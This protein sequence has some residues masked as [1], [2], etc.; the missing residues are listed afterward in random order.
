MLL[1]GEHVLVHAAAF[2]VRD[3][4]VGVGAVGLRHGAALVRQVGCGAQARIQVELR[5]R[6]GVQAQQLVRV[7]VVR[8]QVAGAVGDLLQYRLA[9]VDIL[10]VAPLAA[11]VADA[12]A[13]VVVVVAALVHLAAQSPDADALE[14]VA[15][16]VAE[17]GRLRG[18]LCV[19][20][21]AGGV[22]VGVVAVVDAVTTQVV[23][24]A[25][26]PVALIVV[27][28]AVLQGGDRAAVVLRDHFRGVVVARVEGIGGGGDHTGALVGDAVA[29]QAIV[30]VVAVVGGLLAVAGKAVLHLDL[31]G[32]VAIRVVGVIEAGDHALVRGA[33]GDNVDAARRIVGGGGTGAVGIR[34]VGLPAVGVVVVG[35]DA[36]GRYRC[37]QAVAAV[38]GVVR[39]AAAAA[40]LG[41]VAVVVVFVGDDMAALVDTGQA[42]QWVVVVVGLL[43]N[44]KS[45]G[46]TC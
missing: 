10:H 17:Q 9:V 2:L 6:R 13:L 31:L 27:V 45:V 20:Q 5:A 15:T 3:L 43:N 29:L 14:L 1:A 21:L 16:V 39:G 33:V 19:V 34:H 28:A 24:D 36:L 8:D 46:R 7:A 44:D 23:G 41:A 40:D 35:G 38:E 30:F 12:H 37:G 42:V 26:Q 22:A 11:Q 18:R 25:R 32:A 4:A